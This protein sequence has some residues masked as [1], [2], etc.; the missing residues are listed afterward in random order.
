MT[1]A[2]A[3]EGAKKGRP[4]RYGEPGLSVRAYMLEDLAEG[5]DALAVLAGITRS[6]YICEVMRRHV[7]AKK[8]KR[9]RKTSC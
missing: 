9:R 4:F 5:I 6:E 8:P 1:K 3:K 2:K 7:A